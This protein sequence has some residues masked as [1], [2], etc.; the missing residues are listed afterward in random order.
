MSEAAERRALE[1]RVD[2]W[3]AMGPMTPAEQAALARRLEALTDDEVLE[4]LRRA[5][6][7]RRVARR[8]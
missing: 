4:L 6:E 7:R 8:R 3:N 5:A 2:E 1:A